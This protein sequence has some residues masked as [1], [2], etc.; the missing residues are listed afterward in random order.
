MLLG[1]LHVDLDTAKVTKSG[2]QLRVR[3]N[4]GRQGSRAAVEICHDTGKRTIH[5]HRLVYLAGTQAL[6]PDGF[7]VHHVDE[8]H[9]NNAFSNLVAVSEDDHKKLHGTYSESEVPF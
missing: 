6:I 7:E 3:Y 9:L 5:L 2:K 4:T 8:D 1:E